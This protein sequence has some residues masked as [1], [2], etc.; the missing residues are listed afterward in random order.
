[1]KEISVDLIPVTVRIGNTQISCVSAEL[2]KRPIFS[3]ENGLLGNGL[4]SRFSSVTIDVKGGR[5]VL[6]PRTATP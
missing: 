4:L 2:H 1:L 5:L 6:K 3:G